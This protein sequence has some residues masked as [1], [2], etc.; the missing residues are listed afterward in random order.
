MTTGLI[1]E[2][3][4]TDIRMVGTSITVAQLADHFQQR[5]LGCSNGR[6]SY[7]T[8]KAYQGYLG[9]WIVRVGEP[10]S[11]QTSKP[12]KLRCSS[13]IWKGRQRPAAKSGT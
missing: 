10:T 13:N 11:S 12:S 6:I 5:E 7:S 9:K 4:A 2:I 3:N 1:R 8:K